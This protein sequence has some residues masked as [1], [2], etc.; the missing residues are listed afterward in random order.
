MLLVPSDDTDTAYNDL[1]AFDSM[2]VGILSGSVDGQKFLIWM[3]SNKLHC[4]VYEYDGMDGLMSDV[5]SGRLQAA[6]VSY[7]D[8][9][10]KY[11]TV[12][13]FSPSEYYFMI[14]KD[15]T[16][17]KKELDSAMDD[18]NMYDPEFQ[19][20][21]NEK[22]FSDKRW[23][24]L[25]LSSKEKEYVASAGALT[26]VMQEDN[27][28]FSFRDGEGDIDGVIP[29]FYRNIESMSGLRFRFVCA[30]S[31][32][33]SVRMLKDGSADIVAE[34]PDNYSLAEADDIR[35]TNSY[36][37]MA[38]SQITRQGTKSRDSVGIP[39]YYYPSYIENS[40]NYGYKAHIIQYGNDEKTFDAL[41]KG[42]V[43]AALMNTASATY[44]V[45][46][47]RNGKYHVS[48]LNGQQYRMSSGLAANGNGIMYGLLNKCIEQTGS[49]MM[50]NLVIRYSAVNNGSLTGM[51]NS[52]SAGDIIGV[53]V[54][55][56]VFVFI[57]CAAIILLFRQI[58]LQKSVN[59]EKMKINE[60]ESRIEAER[61][62][63][64]D[65]NQ[66]FSNISHDMRTPLNAI[67]GFSDMAL[68][69]EM[70]DKLR[71]YVAKIRIS[72]DILLD[73]IN[74]TLTISKINSGKYRLNLSPVDIGALLDE[75]TIPLRN[76]AQ[77]KDITMTVDTSG[78]ADRM[79]MAD[80]LNLE[81]IILNLM[82]NAV[83]YTPAGGHVNVVLRDAPQETG[84]AGTVIE[85]RD[86]GIGMSEDFMCHM[87]EP[88]S[89]ENGSN[90]AGGTGLGLSIVREL[91]GLMN[92]QI[93][94]ESRKGHGTV[95]TV[96][97]HF[98]E[99]KDGIAAD[100][101]RKQECVPEGVFAG[102]KLL[103]CEDNPL[104]MEIAAAILNEK[105]FTVVTA[106]NGRIGADKFAGSAEGEFFAIITDIR[107]PVMNG[108][109]L[110][111]AVRKMKRGD[112]AAV[113]II[114]MTADDFD[115]DVIR[116]AQYGMNDHVA[117]PVDISELFS[118]LYRYVDKTDIQSSLS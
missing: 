93:T 35:L 2:K 6:A 109:E 98:D 104:N 71:D 54:I 15:E 66:F 59:I 3:K 40:E 51:I 21:L 13:E 108:Y 111:T 53:F 27:A 107:M 67:I 79:V 116:C 11:R 47:G 5:D 14:N 33:S 84:T 32:Q 112:A 114:A 96:R 46:S 88:F 57:L 45:N 63:N 49:T 12:A 30:D 102:K 43:D 65:R 82:T 115:D 76:A 106:E 72:G 17:L 86:D 113:P 7:S 29:E 103:L 39:S 42:K 1:T 50:N 80:K 28:P 78:A 55:L 73:L 38:M 20:H 16:G 95:F 100:G 52:L 94:A 81:K 101:D 18:L 8:N 99:V 37:D 48:Y 89:Q 68:R 90:K 44:L 64:E 19:S 23:G 87:Y 83:K 74:D 118:K 26:V 110:S 92:G 9:S 62:M 117:K 31:L 69:E 24:K 70:S 10:G 91:V 75:I 77:A 60:T 61:K 22:Y 58:R 85:V 105:G 34:I 56:T 41:K 97:L 4:K 36:L 25:V